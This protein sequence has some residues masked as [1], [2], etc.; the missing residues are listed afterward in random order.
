MVPLSSTLQHDQLGERRDDG[1]GGG[2]LSRFRGRN[3]MI[4]SI[5][6]IPTIGRI[7]PPTPWSEMLPR[8][9]AESDD[10][11][12]RTPRRAGGISAMMIRT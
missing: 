11:R 7:R 8:G 1:H 6:S 3:W 4:R 2:L 9:S 5:A 12:Y 10:G